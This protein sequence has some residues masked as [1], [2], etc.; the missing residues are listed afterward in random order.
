M[1]AS[2]REVITR[3]SSTP[4]GP[5]QIDVIAIYEVDGGKISKV[6][7]KLGSPSFDG[8]ALRRVDICVTGVAP[9]RR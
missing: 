3:F 9:D 2:G 6:W 5:G 8:D 4:E 7:F 1:I